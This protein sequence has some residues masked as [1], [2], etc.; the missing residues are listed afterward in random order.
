M[1]RNTYARGVTYR[2]S[3]DNVIAAAVNAVDENMRE[4]DERTSV[5]RLRKI[6]SAVSRRDDGYGP[7]R[8]ESK[9]RRT[10]AAG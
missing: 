7:R 4:D 8:R 9:R 3:S 6:S 5:S 1:R 2:S 10:E